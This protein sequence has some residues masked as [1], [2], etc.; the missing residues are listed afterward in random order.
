MGLQ[1]INDPLN[2]RI[3]IKPVVKAFLRVEFRIVSCWFLEADR[4]GNSISEALNAGS[5]ISEQNS[6]GSMSIQQGSKQTFVVTGFADE[7]GN[8]RSCFCR[9]LVLPNEAS[10]GFG[11]SGK[12]LFLFKA[13]VVIESIWVEQA[14]SGKVTELAELLWCCGKD[15]KPLAVADSSS[16]FCTRY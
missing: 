6:S 1:Q 15:S 12:V 10:G 7:F 2:S 14:K 5:Y 16:T 3:Y 13:V 4:Q 11:N 9:V 8:F